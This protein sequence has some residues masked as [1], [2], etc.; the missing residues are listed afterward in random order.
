MKY[1]KVMSRRTMLR[2]AGTVAIG[3]P[4]MEAMR[5]TSVFAAAP[6]P[7]VRAYNVFFGLGMPTP[8]H[9]EG[10]SGVIEPLMPVQDKLAILRGVDQVRADE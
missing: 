5:T 1:K 10:Y 3:L 2:G 4:L 7:P 9:S 8:L 6:E